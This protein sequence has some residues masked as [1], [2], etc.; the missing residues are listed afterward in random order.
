MVEFNNFSFY[1]ILMHLSFIYHADR[2]D[3]GVA[4]FIVNG[5]KVPIEETP[6]QAYIELE[7]GYCGGSIIESKWILTA[8]HCTT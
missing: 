2:S 5:D 8:A 3:S 7:G 4:P 6:W 1:L